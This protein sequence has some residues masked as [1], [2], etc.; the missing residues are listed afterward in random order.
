MEINCKYDDLV[1][2]SNIKDHPYNPNQHPIEQIDKL[3][4]YI[5]ETG[6]RLP[7][8]VSN[9]SGYIV[10]GHG[11][12]M[13]AEKLNCKMPVVYQDFASETEERAFLLADNRLAELSEMD[14]GKLN[15]NIGFLCEEN[16][17]LSS[18]GFESKFDL[19]FIEDND[20][21]EKDVEL[22]ND[23]LEAMTTLTVYVK[24]N[25]RKKMFSTLE[26]FKE[27]HGDGVLL[28]QKK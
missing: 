3:V 18:I 22:K 6:W 19:S 26:Q 13:A 17:D 12:K 27:D 8:I 11:R 23:N 15:L 9:L 7:V 4:K 16:F 10:A 14:A 24:K 21:E 2:P 1:N 28:W 5:S 20:E 25:Y